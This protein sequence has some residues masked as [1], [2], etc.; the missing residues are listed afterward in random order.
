MRAN[1]IMHIDPPGVS[2]LQPMTPPALD[3][4]VKNC[5]AKDPDERWQTAHDL[6]SELKWIA[7]GG[8][9]AGAAAIDSRKRRRPAVK[10]I[11]AAAIGVVMAGLGWFGRV[12]IEVEP[13]PVRRFP[14]TLP[15]SVELPTGSGSL[16]AI[17]PDGQTLVYRARESGVFRLYRRSLDQLDATPILGTENAVSEP[18]FSADGQWLGFRVEGTFMKAALA[19]GRPVRVGAIS[20]MRGA[21]WG[22]DDTIIVGALTQGLV[23]LPAGGGEPT[24][25]ATP[26]D[27]RQYW[28]P[29]ILPGGR[30]VLFTAS[31]PQLDAGDVMILDLETGMRRTLVPGGVAGQYV[32]TGHLVFVRGGDLWAIRFDPDRLEVA[33]DAVVVEQGVRVEG[34]GAVQVAVANDGS[35]AYIPGG[36]TAYERRTLVWVDRQG[37]EEAIDMPPRAYRSARLSPD[38]SRV[39]VMIREPQADDIWIW[40]LARDALG[41]LTFGG[42]ANPVWAP[43]GVRIAFGSLE[44]KVYWQAADGSG[45]PEP[46]LADVKRPKNP[47]AF[48][49]DGTQLLVSEVGAPR[50]I[51]LLKLKAG[52]GPESLLGTSFNEDNPEVSPDGRWLAYESNESGRPEVYVRP[53][54]D[55]NSGRWQI[56]TAGGTRPVWN[57]RNG[58][59]LFYLVVPGTVMAVPILNTTAA[60]AAGRPEIVVEGN[61]VVDAAA[62]TYDVSPDGRR[63][64]MIK[65]LE[66]GSDAPP[67]Q[68][69]LVQNWF[70]ELKKRLPGDG[71]RGQ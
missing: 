33:G 26:D 71:K 10:W 8:L 4:V 15:A 48:S 6:N 59:E 38:G 52:P 16:V 24:P 42:G 56:S 40:D 11:A 13:Q 20:N 17:S 45:A 30:A 22:A 35:L 2:V 55:V 14:L 28:Y 61:Y 1:A 68:I 66:A 50:D 39:A 27:G 21:S 37:R 47:R 41:R 53:F 67:P 23:R 44:G 63:F 34:G 70:E 3:R 32:P 64:L 46:L 43:D 12:S 62:R 25:L 54:P 7:E 29:Q 49:P 5:L 51:H 36:G 31:L 9:Q 60:F 19:G 65:D 69:I 57:R 18:F 58:R